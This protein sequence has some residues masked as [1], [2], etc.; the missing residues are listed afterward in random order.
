MVKLTKRYVDAVEPTGQTFF[1]W[2]DA[3]KGFGLRITGN[4]VR[5]Y[6]LQYRRPGGRSRRYTIGRHGSPWTCDEARTKAIELL[7]GL[8]RGIDPLEEHAD[9][10]TAVTV[11]QLADLYLA[12]GPAVKPN[13]RLSVWAADRSNIDR[14][15]RPLLGRKLAT[16]LT[17]ADIARFQIDVAKGRTAT[18]FRTGKPRGRAIVKGGRGAAARSLGVLATMLQFGVNQRLLAAN[19]ARGVPLLRGEKKERFLSDAEVAR[20]GDTLVVMG[21]ESS[22]NP[23]MAAAI[24]LLL[25]TG[26]RKSEIL[27][28]RWEWVNFERRCLDLP[29]SKTGAKTVPLASIALEILAALPRTSVWVLPATRGAGPLVGLDSAW[30]KVRERAE[31]RGL[32]LHDLRHSFASFAVAD[33]SSL[34]LVGKVLGHRHARTTE[35]Y[36][37]VA[38]DPVLAVAER[39]GAR[40]AA[41]LKGDSDGAETVPLGKSKV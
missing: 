40:I 1:R 17:Q 16:E 31:L 7:R 5:A 29:D 27:G 25:V 24:K 37:H 26:C 30:R 19:T 28:L 12:E 22:V 33:G 8:A 21:H 11:N 9:A 34:F 36:A 23:L 15:I 41:A 35:K 6:V 3:V 18:D 13:K 14:H 20:L 4:G 32:R 39:T 38:H 10:R 2:D